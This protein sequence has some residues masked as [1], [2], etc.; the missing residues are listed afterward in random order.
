MA[1]ETAPTVGEET[2]RDALRR[3]GAVGA[4]GRGTQLVEGV[5]ILMLV[6]ADMG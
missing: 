6:E 1:V 3:E 5:M 2:G 4:Q